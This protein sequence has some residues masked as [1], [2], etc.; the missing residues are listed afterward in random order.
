MSMNVAPPQG[1]PGGWVT[2]VTARAESIE[3]AG[4][5]VL[6]YGLVA[7]LLFFGTFKFTETEAKAIEPLV[8]NSPFFSWLHALA[9]TR[10]TSNVV[11]V[12]ELAIAAMIATRRWLPLVS[13]AG[14]LLAVGMFAVTLSFLVTTPGMW[15]SPPDFPVPVPTDIGGFVAKDLFLLGASLW[16]AGEALRATRARSH[17]RIA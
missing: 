14:S 10:G 5:I 4:G 17:Y 12:T 9:G 6:R 7:I 2:A 3:T 1:L 16:S 11:G 15:K 8:A 13:A